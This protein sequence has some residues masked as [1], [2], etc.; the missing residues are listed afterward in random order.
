M[1][2]KNTTD[3]RQHRDEQHWTPKTP[4]FTAADFHFTET[5]AP[6]DL[7]DAPAIVKPVNR[8]Q[9]RK[10]HDARRHVF[11]RDECSRGFWSAIES[12]ITRYP[13]AIMS[14]GRHIA[15]NFLKTRAQAAAV[16]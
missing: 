5:P 4:A 1:Q 3:Y 10:G 12:I 6:A 7:F 13:D 16:F 8:G 9:F 14:D 15:C 11:T 2:E